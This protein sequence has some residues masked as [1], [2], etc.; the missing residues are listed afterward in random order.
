MLSVEE[1]GRVTKIFSDLGIKKLRIT[2]GEPLVRRNFRDIV[3]TINNI[4]DIEE[5]NITT[6]GIRLSE[7]LEFLKDKKIS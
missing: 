2:G 5:I 6:N 1:V 7:E 4:E 3:E